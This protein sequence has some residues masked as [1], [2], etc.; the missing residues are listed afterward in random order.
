MLFL[1]FYKKKKNYYKFITSVFNVYNMHF[2]FLYR[3]VVVLL[4]NFKLLSKKKKILK[5]KV[6]YFNSI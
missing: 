6:K 4:V 5:I 2:Y 3:N 1:F